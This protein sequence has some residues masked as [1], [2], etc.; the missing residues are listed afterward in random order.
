MH[1]PG[2]AEAAE[3][4]QRGGDVEPHGD[5]SDEEH[6]G[7]R[8]LGVPGEVDAG[9]LDAGHGDSVEDVHVLRA[10]RRLVREQVGPG[11]DAAGTGTDEQLE[12]RRRVAAQV[13]PGGGRTSDG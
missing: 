5:E 6:V 9:A 10:Q 4:G 12:A 13:H 3:G 8:S 11:V 1:A 2:A 7:H